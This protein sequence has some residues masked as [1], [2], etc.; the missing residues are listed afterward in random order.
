MLASFSLPQY[1]KR[2]FCKASLPFLSPCHNSP[3]YTHYFLTTMT[4]A[5]I[6][7][8]SSASSCSCSA[9][10]E[11]WTLVSDSQRDKRTNLNSSE[12]KLLLLPPTP[13]NDRPHFLGCRWL[14]RTSHLLLREK[15]TLH[16]IIY[17]WRQQ[18]LIHWLFC[19][20]L[21]H[22]VRIAQYSSLTFLLN[23]SSYY[24]FQSFFTC[25]LCETHTVLGNFSLNLAQVYSSCILHM[26]CII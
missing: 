7:R 5:N 17:D 2:M 18:I 19:W 4:T 23:I 20:R 8:T 26:D 22:F 6:P 9:T 15:H 1:Q 24:S 10:T 11:V 16:V 14:T 12:V 25:F 21:S 13:N 3:K